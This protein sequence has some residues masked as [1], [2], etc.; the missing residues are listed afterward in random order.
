[1]PA[2]QGESPRRRLRFGCIRRSNI[3]PY[4]GLCG[5]RADQPIRATKRA[6]RTGFD[7]ST[8]SFQ[9]LETHLTSLI[10]SGGRKAMIISSS[11]G[12]LSTACVAAMVGELPRDAQS[13]LVWRRKERVDGRV[14]RRLCSIDG[15][16]LEKFTYHI[17]VNFSP[18]HVSSLPSYRT[19]SRYVISYTLTENP[20]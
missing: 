18:S 19:P 14:K 20:H 12:I 5:Y 9:C 3:G 7:V 13:L 6:W 11:S 2:S 17:Q 10:F 1:M 16:S 4:V 15:S 8:I